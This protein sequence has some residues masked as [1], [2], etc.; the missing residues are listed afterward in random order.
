[1]RKKIAITGA[2]L[3]VLLLATASANA[4]SFTIG[5]S[6]LVSVDGSAD[7]SSSSGVGVDLDLFGGKKLVTTGGDNLVTVDTSEDSDALITLFGGSGSGSTGVDVNLG[8]GADDGVSV[9]L[10]GGADAGGGEVTVDPFGGAEETAFI[11][12]FGTGD[13]AGGN[14]PLGATTPDI[15]GPSGSGQTGSSGIDNTQTGSVAGN[16][17]GAGTGGAGAGAAGTGEGGVFGSG[18]QDLTLA[19]SARTRVS[20]TAGVQVQTACFS[21][22]EQQIAN[23][24]ARAT[25]DGS[26][27][28]SWKSASNISIVPIKLCPEARARLAAA[29]DADANIGYLQAAVAAD[30]RLSSS[31]DP[32]YDPEDV[33]AVDKAGDELTIYVF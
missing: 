16:G 32:S 6:G 31:L 30:A 20:A 3:M 22:D 5:G 9:S 2:A 15:F 4:I 28:A 18:A 8:G 10:F 13:D 27:V 19:P 21:P 12:L 1:M 23:L 26:M 25:Y 7:S 33:L 11:S 29:I 14:A 24:R 17:A